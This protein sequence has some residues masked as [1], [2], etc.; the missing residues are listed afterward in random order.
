MYDADCN[1]PF[2]SEYLI[3]IFNFSGITNICSSAVCITDATDWT[4][5][6]DK[7]GP[8][9]NSPWTA[10]SDSRDASSLLANFATVDDADVRDESATA[11]G[12][13]V[14][15]AAADAASKFHARHQQC[16]SN[17]RRHVLR[18]HSAASPKLSHAIAEH[19]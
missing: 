12:S 2:F 18:L 6:Y 5:S 17:A 10:H 1:L 15:T 3:N 11:S 16:S 14:R 8:I 13:T 4:T 7:P 9:P 19:R